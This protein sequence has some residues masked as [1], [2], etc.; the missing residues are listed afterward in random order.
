VIFSSF[1]KSWVPPASFLRPAKAQLWS[2]LFTVFVFLAPLALPAQQHFNGAKALQ[3]AGQFV[4][5]G[6]RWPTSP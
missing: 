6:P 4:A 2:R 1:V 3:Y 5:I